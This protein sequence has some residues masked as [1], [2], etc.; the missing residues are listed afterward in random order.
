MGVL[1]RTRAWRLLLILAVALG[2]FVLQG[3][4]ERLGGAETELAARQ[5]ALLGDQRPEIV[6]PYRCPEAVAFLKQE[7]GARKRRMKLR[8]PGF[9]ES[10]LELVGVN[11]YTG[12]PHRGEVVVQVWTVDSQRVTGKADVWV[13]GLDTDRPRIS[14]VVLRQRSV[15]RVFLPRRS[16]EF[17]AVRGQDITPPASRNLLLQGHGTPGLPPAPRSASILGTPRP[18]GATPSSRDREGAAGNL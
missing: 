14:K 18:S 17:V 8:G 5:P 10:Q 6:I 12:K 15:E 9:P 2:A 3:W 4:L 16:D 1:V 7:Y 13:R 11:D